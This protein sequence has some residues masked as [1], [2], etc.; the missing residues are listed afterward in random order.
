MDVRRARE[1]DIM[2][3]AERIHHVEG[4]NAQEL[5]LV[6]ARLTVGGLARYLRDSW[7]PQRQK[8]QQ[9]YLNDVFADR[10]VVFGAPFGSDEVGYYMVDVGAEFGRA[11]S[12]NDHKFRDQRSNLL[13][14]A[15]MIGKRSDDPGLPD[16]C[17]QL[18][19]GESV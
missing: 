18:V 6:Q 1:L 4:V 8:V 15:K 19:D 11:T 16:Y 7:T 14:T 17:R 12:R 3:V 2:L 5:L 13:K 9:L 10:Q